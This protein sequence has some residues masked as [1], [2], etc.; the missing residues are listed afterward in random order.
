MCLISDGHFA[1]AAR[2]L[3]STVLEVRSNPT[4]VDELCTD[5]GVKLLRGAAKA[6][7]ELTSLS[8]DLSGIAEGL[9]SWWAS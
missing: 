5:L 4:R 1:D 2:L 7:P 9:V 3:V 6:F 8:K